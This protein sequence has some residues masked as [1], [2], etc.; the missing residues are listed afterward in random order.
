MTETPGL[1]GH[2]PPS[3]STP[4]SPL[5]ALSGDVPPG[6]A[7][8]RAEPLPVPRPPR[9]A[10]D[11]R[12]GAPDPFALTPRRRSGAGPRHARDHA[13]MRRQRPGVPRPAGARRA[14]APRGRRDGGMDRRPAGR[15]ARRGRG[16]RRTRSR[17]CSAAPT[18]ARRPASAGRSPS[19]ARCP[20]PVPPDAI[21]AY[22]M[23]GAPLPAEHGAPFRLIVPGWYGMA[24][25]KWLTEIVAIATPF[26]GFYQADRYVIGDAPL[27]EMA[28]R[29]AHRRPG[30]R[31]DGRR[32][33][34]DHPR[35][36]LV[37]PHHRSSGSRS[38]RTAAR[39]G[40]TRR[41]GPCRAEPGGPGS[42]PWAASAGPCH[43]ARPR[44]RCPRR[45][46]TAR[47]GP[48]RPRLP[49]QRGPA[50]D[51]GGRRPV[52][53][54]GAR[55]ASA[56]V[57]QRLDLADEL[58]D[59]LDVVRRRLLGDHRPEAEL[60]VRDEL[61]GDLL[62]R[63]EP[64]R[65]V[66]VEL[67]SRASCCARARRPGRAGLGLG[68][69]RMQALMPSVNSISET[70]RPTSAQCWRRTSTLWAITSSGPIAFQ[71]SAYL[72]TVRRVF[73]SPEPPIMI[74]RWGWTGSGTVAQ[75]SDRVVA[76]RP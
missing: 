56:L 64:E 19:N 37:R 17:S 76:G 43:P 59:R 11:R 72:A 57:D 46:P 69:A 21:V 28:P 35:L 49:E 18:R 9:H 75:S 22:A 20:L 44:D 5:E 50:G 47:P 34:D 26:R 4:R 27:N 15:P 14:V 62:R 10:D 31:R 36:R 74:G 42:W 13:R 55:R 40:P 52:A 70:S 3:R 66:L 68:R 7:P 71:M 73:F 29:A 39:A 53:D 65:V 30:R 23:N 51:R 48:E 45:A 24:S 1:P 61:L 32:R 16:G 67:S 25:V 8:L 58:L 2:Q 33:P 60:D 12:R 38:A 63:A 54:A 41:S 6:R